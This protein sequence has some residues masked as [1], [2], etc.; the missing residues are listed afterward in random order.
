LIITLA[1]CVDLL[2][3]E[4]TEVLSCTPSL[5]VVLDKVV[6]GTFGKV[7]RRSCGPPTRLVGPTDRSTGL[8]VGQTHLSGIAMSLVAGDPGVPMSH[9]PPREV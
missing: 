3:S 9:K 2:W 8:L 4:Y 1:I 6:W 5:E 7:F